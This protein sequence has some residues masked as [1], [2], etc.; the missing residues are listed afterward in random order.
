ML[1]SPMLKQCLSSVEL[2]HVHFHE[3]SRFGMWMMLLAHG[4]FILRWLSHFH[5]CVNQQVGGSTNQRGLSN[6]DLIGFD[7]RW[8]GVKRPMKRTP[9]KGQIIDIHLVKSTVMARNTA[10]LYVEP[11]LQN[12]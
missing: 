5:E 6:E 7:Q 1:E 12:I 11:H 4:E 2:D 10:Y 8:D 3:F 9:P